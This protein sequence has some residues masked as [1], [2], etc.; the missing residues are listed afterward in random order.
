MMEFINAAYKVST[1]W[2]FQLEFIYT[3]YLI[4]FFNKT[5]FHQLSLYGQDLEILLCCFG[6]FSY[7]FP[8]YASLT[9][10]HGMTIALFFLRSPY[11]V[12]CQIIS[13]MQSNPSLEY[14]C[15]SGINIQDQSLKHLFCCFHHMHPT[16]LRS[17]G[18][19]LDTKA[20]WLTRLFLRYGLVFSFK[21]S[22]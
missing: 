12:C 21:V 9:S 8:Y 15:F 17:F 3:V 10:F 6:I 22:L 20:H 1:I 19:A 11:L 16:W 2:L 13:H 7:H 5:C 4:C 14:L 18:F